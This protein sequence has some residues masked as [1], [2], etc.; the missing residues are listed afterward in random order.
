MNKKFTIKA[1][2]PVLAATMLFSACSTGG[3]NAPALMSGNSPFNSS[4]QAS[5]TLSD[6]E[7]WSTYATEK[8]LQDNHTLYT[9]IKKEAAISVAAVRGEEEAAQIIMTSGDKPVSGYNVTV[10]NLNDGKGNEFNKNNVKVYHQRYIKVSSANEHYI[11]PGNYPDCLVPFEKVKAVN[12]NNFAANSNQGLYV[13]FVIPENQPAGV[14][15]GNITINISGENKNIPVSLKVVDAAIGE[16]THTQSIFLNEWYFYRGELD[17]TEEMYDAYN[18][19]LF[20]YRLGCN[21]V[22]LTTKD[23]DYYAQKVCEYAANPKCPAYN[24]PYFPL[25]CQGKG[26]YLN[27]KELKGHYAYNPTLLEKYFTVIAYEGFEKNV[28]PFKKAVIYGYDEPSLNFAGRYEEAYT[29]QC[30][31]EWSYIVRQCKNNVIDELNKD[32]RV[33]THPLFEEVINSLDKIPHVITES[34]YYSKLGEDLEEEDIVYAPV[35]SRLGTDVAREQYRLSEDNALWWYGCSAPNAPYP[36]YHIDD[37]LL[38]ARLASWMQ[39]DYNIQGILYWST[40]YYMDTVNGKGVLQE[41]FYSGAANRCSN[42]DGEGFLMYPG[43]KY[44]VYG[45]LPS[46]RLEQIRDGL[47]EYEMLYEMAKIYS[48]VS[49][50][51]GLVCDQS[52]IMQYVYETMYSGA[53]VNCSNE[54]FARQRDVLLNLFE[55]ASSPARVCV[56]SVSEVGGKYLFKVYSESENLKQ[57]GQD[58]LLKESCGDGYVYTINSE[59][60]TQNELDL[61]VAV[62]SGESQKTYGVQMDFGKGAIAYGAEYLYENDMIVK[63]RTDIEVCAP[64]DATSVNPNANIGDKY[65]QIKMSEAKETAQDF[66]IV[67]DVIKAIGKNDRKLVIRLY[68]NSSNTVK[69]T[70]YVKYQYDGKQQGY[71]AYASDISLTPG[72]NTFVING[73]DS[74]LWQR[75]VRINE[76]RFAFGAKGD[77]ARDYIYFMDMSVFS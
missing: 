24:I 1:L 18:Q 37:T 14:Y 29:I 38:S 42:V 32:A 71:D 34:S 43:A 21:D 23:V 69:T 51:T 63:R 40:N 4:I 9:N 44:G 12:E 15:S 60:G 3:A 70:L 28:D 49:Q 36:T 8:V 27:G 35:F 61:S 73:L 33:N 58:I 45:P 56:M 20:N 10:S 39:F 17:E 62:G 77:A 72:E 50:E 54:N 46:V 26:I 16:E 25:N 13:S 48:E 19:M 30:I 66:L 2:A 68:N 57:G 5:S 11:T 31:K 64:T 65:L 47:E 67:G 53:A 41:D 22:T 59:L 6:V 76:I 52:S 7:F 75:L 74:M 55:L